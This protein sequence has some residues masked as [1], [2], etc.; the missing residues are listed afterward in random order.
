[1]NDDHPE[2]KL[3]YSLLKSRFVTKLVS[4]FLIV[5]TVFIG[6]KAVHAIMNFDS[7]DQPVTN[8]ITVQGEG[9][10]SAAPDIASISFT[11]SE[12]ADTSAKAQDAAQKKVSA[13]LAALKNL[14][15]ADKDIKT[16]S[17]SVYPRYAS[18]QPCY[19]NIPCPY[20]GEQK[21]IGFTASQTVEVK[22]RVIDDTGKVLTALGGAG[23]SNLYGPNFTIDDEDAVKAKAR[24]DAI[25]D[26]RAKANQ[27]AS[28]LGV[29]LVK[30]V[31]YSENGGYPVMYAKTD[32]SMAM[33][34][35]TPPRE[36]ASVP[37]G[38]NEIV[39]NVSV[40][41]EIR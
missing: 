2:D 37:T 25:Q 24:K 6:A 41:Y 16:G 12:D 35:A 15:I 31:N 14:K 13:A 10:V 21:V 38:E 39:V 11:V 22:V 34:A 5:C 33:G 29:R 3:N 26:A 4:A 17:Y 7:A 9:K 18:Q 36:S 40:T 27:L 20:N 8:V 19:A 30:V 23:I 1:M 28:D 32:A